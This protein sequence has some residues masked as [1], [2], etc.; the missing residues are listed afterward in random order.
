MTEVLA[1][2]DGIVRHF[3]P[4][5]ALNGSDLELRVG[6]V[7]GVLGENGA[8]KSTLLN[9]LCG[10]LSADAGTLTLRGKPVTLRSPRD[11]WANG[12]GL[13]HQHFKLVRRL[14]VLE[15]LSLGR[16]T[17]SRGWKLPL[18]EVAERAGELRAQTGLTVPLHAVVE[19]LGVG[20]RQRVEILK[21]LLRGP[22]LLILDEPTAVLSP[23]EVEKLL[24]LLRALAT[25]GRAVVLVSHK[26]DEVL[27]VCDHVTV[28]RGGRT[29]LSVRRSEVDASV[30]TRAMVGVEP[31]TDSPPKQRPTPAEPEATRG[32]RREHR[33]TTSGGKVVARLRDVSATGPRGQ[34]ALRGVSLELR[35]GEILGVAGVEGNGQRELALILAGRAQPMSG[36]VEIPTGTGF[37]PE[38]R[39]SEGLAL[40]FDLAENLALTLHRDDRFR[41]GAL[42]KWGEITARADRLRREFAVQ[43]ADTE[44]L[45]GTLSGGNQQRL[46]V[47]RELSVSTDLLVAEN[48]TRGLDVLATEFV[49]RRIRE[50]ATVGPAP[51][52]SGPR[53][54]EAA[55][56]AVVLISADLDEVLALSDRILVM[57]RGR[58]VEVPPDQRTRAGV[59]ALMLGVAAATGEQSPDGARPDEA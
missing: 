54:P 9:I 22:E 55:G 52:G 42:L 25:D 10:M 29:V 34:T 41:S 50:A 56:A 19:D 46:V 31:P 21:A 38:D 57:A 13:V 6:E 51:G 48:P 36:D 3:G 7:H 33:S 45:A 30:L 53:G 59:G 15:N 5:T 17:A 47:G 24:A 14:T 58:L 44:V 12:I 28:L 26:L 43:A 23:P 2:L 16:R 8:G 18:R 4:V 1:R 11:A 35:R 32:S 40:D 39:T 37:I 27:S 20:D 49:R